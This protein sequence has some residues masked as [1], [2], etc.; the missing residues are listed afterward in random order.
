MQFIV[1][2]LIVSTQSIQAMPPEEAR[3]LL[4][5]TGFGVSHSQWQ[6]IIDLDYESAVDKLVDEASR[7]RVA[8]APEWTDEKPL[9]TIRQGGWTKEQRRELRLDKRAKIKELREW[10]I[11]Q[12]LATPTPL[13]ERMTMFWSNHFTTQY[14]KSYA[15][16]LLYQQHALLRTHALKRFDHMLLAVL[17]DPAMLLYLDNDKNNANSVNENLARELMELF[18]L[19]EGNYTERDVKEAARCLTGWGVKRDTGKFRVS[20]K[21][22]DS[23]RKTVLGQSGKYSGDD[24]A[25]LLL[26][27]SATAERVVRKLW[28]EFVSLEPDEKIIKAWAREFSKNDFAIDVMLKT[29]FK[30]PQ[31]R[32]QKNRGVLVKSPTEL[33]IGLMRPGVDGLTAAQVRERVATIGPGKR[34]PRLF[35]IAGQNLFEPPSVE[36]WSGGLEWVDSRSL[37]A[38]EHTARNLVVGLGDAERGATNPYLRA[39]GKDSK[40]RRLTYINAVDPVTDIPATYTQQR[41][42]LELIRDPAVHVK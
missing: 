19:G 10:W 18:T 29:I 23:G 26:A 35:Q 25:K 2:I 31:F 42:L 39:L 15:P 8:K 22:H 9:W 16:M 38:R 5:R 14:S 32:A 41:R 24:L 37:L 40:G 12:M 1:P 21:R 13:Q 6:S 17:R 27:K 3:H 30:S 11:V 36:G 20:A 4:H 33:F 7:G 28:L 34:L